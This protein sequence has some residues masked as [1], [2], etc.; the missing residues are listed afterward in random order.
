[1]KKRDHK[2]P[3]Y[4]ISEKGDSDEMFE[5]VKDYFKLDLEEFKPLSRCVKCNGDEIEVI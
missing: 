3:V 4:C 5:E 2:V 1:M